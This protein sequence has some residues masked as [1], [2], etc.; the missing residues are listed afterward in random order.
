MRQKSSFACAQ[1][2]TG[3]SGGQWEQML[4]TLIST[5]L[6]SEWS[7]FLGSHPQ[8][9]GKGLVLLLERIK[10]PWKE[11]LGWD[12]SEFGWVPNPSLLLGRALGSFCHPEFGDG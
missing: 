2:C 7:S 10:K 8:Q 5:V 1:L 4:W 12:E 3:F 11:A 6:P 9:E